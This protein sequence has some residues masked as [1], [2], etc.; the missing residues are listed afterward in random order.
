M[1]KQPFNSSALIEMINLKYQQFIHMLKELNSIAEYFLDDQGYSLSFSIAKGTDQSFLWKFTIRIVCAKS[2]VG[3]T[4]IKSYRML[5]LAQFLNIYNYIK[6]HTEA[7]KV[8]QPDF[9][10]ANNN[11]QLTFSKIDSL[12]E[13]NSIAKAEASNACCS[14]KSIMTESK[15]YDVISESMINY[16][17]KEEETCCIC[18]ESRPNL[19][20]NCAHNFC[21]NCIKEWKIS[22]NTCPICRCI[23][24]ES[25]C[26]VLADKPD[27]YHIQDEI[28]KSL[29]Q[30]TEP[31]K[32]SKSTPV[33]SSSTNPFVNQSNSDREEDDSD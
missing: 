33:R 20:L 2:K 25:D 11:D 22:S 12:T 9:Q 24:E 23:S 14:T 16:N 19:I 27:Y 26:F 28:S 10:S 1:E 32:K 29:F 4:D 3:T 21:E 8:F 15:L 31:I 7:L 13:E 6:Q 30:I 18:M 5:K 17:Q